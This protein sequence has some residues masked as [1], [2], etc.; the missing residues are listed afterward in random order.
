[1]TFPIA[2]IISPYLIFWLK[3]PNGKQSIESLVADVAWGLYP[4]RIQY[5]EHPSI[6]APF[7]YG[8]PNRS[9]M[10]RPSIIGIRKVMGDTYL[11]PKLRKSQKRTQHIDPYQAVFLPWFDSG[12]SGICLIRSFWPVVRRDVSVGTPPPPSMKSKTVSEYFKLCWV[13]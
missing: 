12:A 9:P 1:M 4:L 2:A 8:V 5:E 10:R 13:R 6:R 7:G 11:P 3:S